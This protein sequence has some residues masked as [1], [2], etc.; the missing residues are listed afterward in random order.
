VSVTPPPA[1]AASRLESS[2]SMIVRHEQGLYNVRD[3]QRE[4]ELSED[5]DLAEPREAV[6]HQDIYRRG[7]RPLAVQYSVSSCASASRLPCQTDFIPPAGSPNVSFRGAPDEVIKQC[8]ACGARVAVP[9]GKCCFVLL[10]E[11]L[12]RV[13]CVL[14]PGRTSQ[15]WSLW[16]WPARQHRDVRLTLATS[17]TAR[18]QFRRS[19]MRACS[20]G[21]RICTSF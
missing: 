16:Q 2:N 21:T 9:L 11:I 18:L 5:S 6:E 12:Y 14:S 20:Q 19:S 3:S 8:A 17:C 15:R 10:M 1:R 4:L 7:E 13:A